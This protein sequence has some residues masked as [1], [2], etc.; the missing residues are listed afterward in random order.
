MRYLLDTNT[1]IALLNDANSPVT[2]RAR[3]D[4]AGDVAIS[5]IVTHELYY[6]AC[7]SPQTARNVALVDALRFI[8]PEFD[9]EDARLAGE[10]RALLTSRGTPI[11]PYDPLFA[12]LDH[13]HGYADMALLR[14]S[15]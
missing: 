1:V 3:R 15:S 2:R 6:G 9:K 14:C 13:G 5:A 8:V 4:R 10:V 12:F 11:G 7:K